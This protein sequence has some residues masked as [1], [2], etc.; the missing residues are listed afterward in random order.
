MLDWRICRHGRRAHTHVKMCK[1]RGRYVVPF[2]IKTLNFQY[3]FNWVTWKLIKLPLKCQKEHLVPSERA[4]WKKKKKKISTPLSSIVFSTYFLSFFP[5]ISWWVCADHS[6][7]PLVLNYRSRIFRLKSESWTVSKV[8]Q[9][10][11]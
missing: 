1:T 2:V 4:C 11:Q 3:L 9:P 6:V 5:N 10:S 8:Q 7:M